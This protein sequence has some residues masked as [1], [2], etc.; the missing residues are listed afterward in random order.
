MATK[1]KNKR[2][3]KDRAKAATNK[4][5]AY[6]QSYKADIYA[7]YSIGYNQGLQ[8]GAKIP[9]RFGS[10]TVAVVGYNKGIGVSR[11][12]NKRNKRN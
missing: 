10:K 5:K 4:V 9:K 1:T 6:G 2:S 7:A 11:K 3:F 12:Q 8:D